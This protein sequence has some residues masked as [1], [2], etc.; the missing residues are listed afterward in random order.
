MLIFALTKTELGKAPQYIS[1]VMSIAQICD[2]I[3]VISLVG[4]YRSAL[5][6]LLGREVGAGGK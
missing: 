5:C 2:P 1:S 6:K 4:N 3:L